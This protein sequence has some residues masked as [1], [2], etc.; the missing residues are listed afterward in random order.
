MLLMRQQICSRRP[1]QAPTGVFPPNESALHG[2]VNMRASLSPLDPVY[3]GHGPK[4][5]PLSD[6]RG[7]TGLCKYS[8][9]VGEAFLVFCLLA[10]RNKLQEAANGTVHGALTQ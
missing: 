9:R 3:R 6:P 10:F 1:I 7:G 8:S 5:S 4:G 2:G